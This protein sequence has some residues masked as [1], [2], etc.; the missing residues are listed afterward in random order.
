MLKTDLAHPIE[1]VG[2]R[3]RAHMPWLEAT[4]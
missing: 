1:K 3:L 4:R 2:V